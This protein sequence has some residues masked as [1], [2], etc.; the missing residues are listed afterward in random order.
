MKNG[1][2]HGPVP[3]QQLQHGAQNQYTNSHHPH[4]S[5]PDTQGYFLAHTNLSP[6]GYPSPLLNPLQSQLNP[7]QPASFPCFPP[8]QE[9]LLNQRHQTKVPVQQQPSTSHTSRSTTA[10]E[11][12]V[13]DTCMEEEIQWQ[14]VKGTKRKK[15]RLSVDP[16]SQAIPLVNRYHV[17]T[18]PR[19]TATNTGPAETT[20][21]KPP[22]I[23]IYD[24]TNLPEMRKR[25]NEFINEEH[26]TIK[27]LANNTI[28]LLCQNPD[29]FRKLA[30]YMKEK[31]IIHHTYQ[32]KEERSYRIVIRHLHHSVD[33][34]ELKEEIS[35]L[36]HTVRNII[37]ARHRI[38]KDPLNLFFVDLEPSGNNKDIYKITRLQNS[39]IQIEPP[40]HGKHIVQCT[41]CQLYGHTKSYC[42]RPFVCVKCGGQHSTASCKKNN[43][44]PATCALCGGD[45]PANYKGCN[46]YQK[47]Y[48]AKYSN[49]RPYTT[50]SPSMDLPPQPQAIP[51]SQHKTYAQ[52]LRG[53]ESTLTPPFPNVDEPMSLP[54]FLSEFKA[55][56]QQLIQQNTMVLNMLT[57]LINK[58]NNG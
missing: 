6:T 4:P 7:L 28:K 24:V 26:Y 8:N 11:D 10:S 25:F 33:I 38:T 36:G 46:F 52:A 20:T 2:D 50:N 17:L 56:F 23:F 29:T 37:N 55:M 39:V 19:N 22:P 45:H 51:R 14:T 1:P 35:N 27:S 43:T 57:M 49:Q 47:Q 44:T 58:M 40:R 16:T 30:K 32:P 9:Q 13:D 53:A 18:D 42:N 5:F 34:Q 15:H 41:R 31:N 48:H 21:V 3:S 54:T 12:E